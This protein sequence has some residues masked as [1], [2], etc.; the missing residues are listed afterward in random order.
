[1]DWKDAVIW[2]L[3]FITAGLLL[4]GV[5]AGIIIGKIF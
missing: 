3:K 4:V 2:L 5:L 1:M